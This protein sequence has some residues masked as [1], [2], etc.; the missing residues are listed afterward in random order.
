MNQPKGNALAEIGV[1]ESQ[2]QLAIAKA[3]RN[4]SR[5]SVIKILRAAQLLYEAEEMVPGIV[6]RFGSA[7]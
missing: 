1:A 7:S 6:K 5:G 3:L 2:A 4:L